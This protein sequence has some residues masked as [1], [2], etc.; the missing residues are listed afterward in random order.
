MSSSFLNSGAV[1][2]GGLKGEDDE[3]GGQHRGTEDTER[4]ERSPYSPFKYGFLHSVAVFHGRNVHFRGLSANSAGCESS[5]R[6]GEF[7]GR[8]KPEKPL[9]KQI[10][11]GPRPQEIV[12]DPPPLLFQRIAQGDLIRFSRVKVLHDDFRRG[13]RHAKDALLNPVGRVCSTGRFL[14][15]SAVRV[16]RIVF[17]VP[18][19]R[20][21]DEIRPPSGAGH[22]QPHG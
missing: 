22:E 10:L 2:L 13:R 3:G 19:F 18:C 21:F 20:C 11:A 12:F 4:E 17:A 15:N 5:G 16:D 14:T 6:T 9:A 1:F 8:A 7:F